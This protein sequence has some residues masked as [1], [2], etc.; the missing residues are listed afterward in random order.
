VTH[1]SLRSRAPWVARCLL[2]AACLLLIAPAAA[3]AHALL[4]RTSPERGAD[5]ERQ[6]KQVAFYFNEPVES[7]FGAVR[8]FDSSGA[9]VQSGDVLRPGDDGK[10]VAVALQPNLPDGTY[11]ATYRVVSADSHPVSGGVVFSIGKPDRGGAPIADLLD[12]QSGPGTDSAAFVVDRW[13]GYLATAMLAG[14]LLFLVAVWRPALA[15]SS[16]AAPDLG[17]AAGAFESRLRRSAGI[18]ALVGL[19]SALAALPLQA[20]TAAGV[21]LLDGFDTDLISQ[22]LDTRFGT[23]AA[24]RSVA[25]LILVLLIWLVPRRSW[26]RSTALVGLVALPIAALLVAPGLGGHASTQSP[27]A[28]LLPADVIH[29]AAMSGWLGGLVAL[30]LAVPAGSRLLPRERRS[31]LVSGCLERFSPIAL[32]S[33][34]A[35]ALTGTIQ[36]IIEV[37]S[38]PALVD[39]G[40]G[41]A[42]LAKILLLAVLIG[43]GWSNRNRLMPAIR[44]L[45]GAGSPLAK[46]GMKLRNNLQIE[47][48]LIG[49][50]LVASALLVGYAPSSETAEGPVSG[51]ATLGDA[52]LEYTVEP[53]TVGSNQVH[54]YLFDADDGSQLDPKEV[55]A[56]AS[57]SDRDVGPL[58]IDLRKAGPGHYT[59]PAAQFGIAGDWDLTVTV[60]TSRFDENEAQLT[61]P[62]D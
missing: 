24:I 16:A 56:V 38:F 59:A 26:A 15:R 10:G 45:A 31:E 37:G 60:R 44:S 9:E 55:T 1:R 14:G 61:V 52:Y 43:L 62:I 35:L 50:V 33:V 39:T 20:S 57:L 46:L 2:I 47:V 22:V 41:R 54:L 6:P 27:G 17:E 29:M 4:E 42:V 49:T 32:G 21:S 7:E 51:T 28:L 5:V 48:A 12:G 30:V 11:T 3:Q 58:P 13:L 19:L 8:V 18:A 36:A 34:I 23:L 40:F 25:W 53:A